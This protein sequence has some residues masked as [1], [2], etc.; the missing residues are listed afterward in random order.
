[1]AVLRAAMSRR[2]GA[3]RAAGSGSVPRWADAL[4]GRRR[5]DDLRQRLA[6]P[7]HG[8]RRGAGGVGST[9]TSCARPR[10]PRAPRRR[11][12]AASSGWT[13]AVVA[14]SRRVL[15]LW[16]HRFVTD[17]WGWEVPAGRLD[18]GE[19]ARRPRPRAARGDR[20]GAGT[21]SVLTTFPR[22]GLVDL[23]LH[24]FAADGATRV[25]S[26][27]DV[28]E[29][30]RVEWVEVAGCGT[31]SRTD[32]GRRPVAD[33]AAV[34]VHLRSPVTGPVRSALHATIVLG[35]DARVPEE[36]GRLRQAGRS[37]RATA[38]WPPPPGRS[39]PRRRQ[40]LRVHR[41]GPAG[42]DRHRSWPSPSAPGTRRR[43]S[44]SPAAWPS[45]TATSWP[46]RCP[47][48]TW[49]PASA[50][51]R[52]PAP[53]SSRRRRWPSVAPA[54][55]CPS[56][57]LLEPAPARA[58]AAPWAYVKI[59]EGCDRTCGFCAIPTLPGPAAQPRRRRPIL[60][61]VDAA[62]GPGDR[63]RRPGPGVATGATRAGAGAG[64][65]SRSSRPWP[66]RVDRV[67]LL[68]LY[69]S[70]LTDGLID[71]ILRHRRARTSTSR[72]STSSSPL[73]RRMRRWGD[74][75]RFLRADR[76]HPRPA[77]PTPRSAPTSSSATRARP[78]T[79]TTQLLA[80]VEAAQLDWCGFFAYSPEDGTYAAGLDGAGADGADG[81]AAG[82]AARAAGRAS[83]PTDVTS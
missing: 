72:C 34:G 58:S 46:R 64:R 33:R 15:L 39:R 38:S 76:R 25:G 30:E 9:T 51:T 18:E 63:A 48:S 44:W 7:G 81:R 42:V 8:R 29:S 27:V 3:R 77:S 75:D 43:G 35:R 52:S 78:R 1:M 45:A 21:A 4:G 53:S 67:R 80:F 71:V 26:P 59:A 69:P 13:P 32:G 31:R 41:G 68:Y 28:S 79:T 66:Q 6:A 36:P 16:R 65:S 82:R 37:A 23:R 73:L 17:Q 19:T 70:D 10:T 11:A 49:S 55:R 12:V 20:L 60:D 50:S 24:L 74:G 61:E 57:D 5:A 14:D 56:F 2:P 62:R 83:P 40:H 22:V 47:R 54:D